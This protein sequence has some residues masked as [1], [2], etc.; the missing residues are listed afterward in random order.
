MIIVEQVSSWYGDTFWGVYAQEF[1]SWVLGRTTP[2][3]LRN[4]QIDFQRSCTCL[5][6]TSNGGVFTFHHILTSMWF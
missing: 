3:F 4:G 2:N 5:H 1:Y 6:P